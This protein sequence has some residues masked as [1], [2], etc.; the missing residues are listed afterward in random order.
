ME[1]LKQNKLILIVVIIV[2]A[3][4]IWYGMSSSNK[5]PNTLLTA[6][7]TS[8]TDTG[9]RELLKLLTDMKSIRLD[10]DIFKS[11]AYLSLQDFS[12]DI[13]GEPVGREDPFA[14][15]NKTEVTLTGGGDSTNQTPLGN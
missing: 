6:T 11:D 5:T 7:Q 13:V 2:I 1:I 15:V 8:E 12:R 9:D 10:G 14:P 4:L 3:L